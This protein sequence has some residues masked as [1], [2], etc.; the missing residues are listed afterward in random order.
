MCELRCGTNRAGGDIGR[1]H[2]DATSRVYKQY[3]SLNEEAELRPAYRVFFSGCNFR[4]PFCDEAPA[5]FDPSRGQPVQVAPLAD[6]LQRAMTQGARVI[7]ILGGEPTLHPHTLLEIAAA[8]RLPLA[9]NSNMY[10]TPRVLDLLDGAVDWYLADYKFGN[11]ACASELAGVSDYTRIVRRNLLLAAERAQVIVRHVLLPSH[12]D[13]CFYPLSNWVAEHLPGVRFQLYPGYVP[14][15][16]AACDPDIGQLN[17]RADVEA[18][19]RHLRELD[20]RA[21][22]GLM[23]GAQAYTASPDD[24]ATEVSLTIGSDGRIYCHDLSGNLLPVL[25]AMCAIDPELKR[26]A[27][28]PL[29]RGEERA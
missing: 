5:A 13:C 14:C 11:D 10:M 28:A 26:S 16:P 19:C 18:A 8:K 29:K 22:A 1:C 20:V 21:D 15:G 9:V 27:D 4:C 17:S 12:L 7:S 25:E 2:L 24:S 3:P 23:P 6:R